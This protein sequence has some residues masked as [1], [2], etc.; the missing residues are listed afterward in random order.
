MSQMVAEFD[1]WQS[2]KHRHAYHSAR[3]R[4]SER[5]GVS[6]LDSLEVTPAA[7]RDMALSVFAA[8]VRHIFGA[9]CTAKVA[10]LVERQEENPL[11]ALGVLAT[12]KA[13]AEHADRM[14]ESLPEQPAGAM[15]EV[16]EAETP[17]ILEEVLCE[18]LDAAV[19]ERIQT[20]APAQT[21]A[22]D[23]R[24]EISQ[25]LPTTVNPTTTPYIWRQVP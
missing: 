7:R 11:L 16:R 20:S 13:T 6:V 23:Q 21:L 15:R 4:V 8:D 19:R 25:N 12:G 2:M 5:L 18:W 17:A 3:R 22:A 24:S 1:E 9:A 10:R 14:A